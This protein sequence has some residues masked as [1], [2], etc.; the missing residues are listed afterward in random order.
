MLAEANMLP[1]PKAGAAA[2]LD[3]PAEPAAAHEP[4]SITIN[5]AAPIVTVHTPDVHIA[6]GDTH[7]TL[8]E[9]TIQLDAHIAQ[10]DIKVTAPIVN[11]EVPP[12]QVVM[13]PAAPQAT[14]QIVTRDANGEMTEI[15]TRPIDP[16]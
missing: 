15:V 7:V 11:V 9:S 8:P 12:T 3:K 10:P 16:Q 1:V 14:R 13:Q 5:Q 4:P 2:P 6:Q